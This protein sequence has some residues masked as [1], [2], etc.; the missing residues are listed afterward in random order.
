MKKQITTTILA[1]VVALAP[2][3]TL[4]QTPTDAMKKDETMMKD[5]AMMEKNTMVKKEDD[6]MM[7]KDETKK[8][9]KKEML[10]AKK[11]AAMA[12][13]KAM[14][15]KAMME[16]DKAMMKDKAMTDKEAMMKKSTGYMIMGKTSL[17]DLKKL[18]VIGNK[19]VVFFHAPW[20]PTCKAADSEIMKSGVKDGY[21]IV[22]VD[23]DDSTDLK[24]MY[25]VTTQHTFVQVDEM[26]TLITSWKGGGVADIYKNVK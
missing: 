4:A 1:G 12:K 26:G 24:K 14:K 15:A 8:M 22:R 3:T 6:T 19:N 7:K 17:E 13:A 18:I 21:N 2:F 11:K 9:S 20:C 25:G 16:K 5:K 10:M 23:Y